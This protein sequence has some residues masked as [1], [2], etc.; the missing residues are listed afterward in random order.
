M[1]T[2]ADEAKVN[3]VLNMLVGASSESARTESV[4]A[5]AGRVFCE[6][7]GAYSPGGARRK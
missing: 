5:V 6:D 3:A 2:T 7:E 1:Q 4:S